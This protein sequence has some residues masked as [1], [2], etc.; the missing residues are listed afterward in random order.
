MQ[1]DDLDAP[2]ENL[3]GGVDAKALEDAVERLD[4]V[5]GDFEHLRL[6]P[7]PHVNRR[8]PR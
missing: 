3:R 6:L 7:G 1:L 4:A 8:C 2:Q 5:Q